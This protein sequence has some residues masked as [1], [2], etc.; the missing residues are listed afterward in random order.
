MIALKLYQWWGIVGVFNRVKAKI[1]RYK[2]SVIAVASLVLFFLLI[3]WTFFQLASSSIEKSRL[4]RSELFDRDLR[5]LIG[6]YDSDERYVLEKNLSQF[7]SEQ[8]PLAPLLLPRQY[9]VALPSGTSKF[10]PR[11]PPRN[12]F[13]DLVKLGSKSIS[14]QK[15]PEKFCAYFAENK[16]VGS[17]L[18]FSMAF[19]DTEINTLRTGDVSFGADSVKISVEN[20]GVRNTWW[21]LLQSPKNLANGERFQLTAFREKTDGVKE[22][23]KRIEGWAYVQKQANNSTVVNLIARLDFK[24][25]YTSQESEIWPPKYWEKTRIQLSRN[26]VSA[27]NNIEQIQ[28]ENTGFS[29]L[30][31]PSLS[32]SIFNAYASL[33]VIA[34]RT[35][36]PVIPS[37]SVK[38]KLKNSAD[39][40]RFVDGDL[41]IRQNPI[42]R[43]Q[44]LQDTSIS[45][46]VRHPGAVIEQSI[47]KTA[48]FIILLLLGFIALAAFFFFQL[49]KPIWILSRHSRQLIKQSS[50][51]ADLPYSD[52]NDEIGALSK[53]FNELLRETR[54]Q[55]A[56]EHEDREKRAEELRKKHIEDVK[57]REI[58]LQVIG[59]E[60]R[61]PLQALKSLHTEQS[62]S[63]R[64]IDRITR[65]VT[66][67][68][69]ASGPEAAFA[70]REINL[71]LLDLGSFLFEVAQNSPLANIPNVVFKGPKSGVNVN[72]D[73]SVLEDALTNILTNGNRHRLQNSPL[74]INL[75]HDTANAIIDVFNDG[76][77][78]PENMLEQIF[79]LYF[80]TENISENQLHGIGLY[81]AKNYISRMDGTI[82][83]HNELLG[84]SF[85]ITLPLNI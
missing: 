18:F 39:F 64:Y 17:Y 9:Y 19:V 23:D 1:G 27:Q 40:I 22:L 25:F 65:A 4:I 63:W 47:W 77:H 34:D 26:D 2:L 35:S 33:N 28:Y 6:H 75:S 70:L 45:F 53:G 3:I 79:E 68:F 58:N 59:H 54:D 62:K 31:I 74:L 56:R 37:G 52:R 55:S 61:S 69:G 13:V 20:G 84:V 42:V 50:S 51:R 43:S 66:Q 14:S 29:N 16:N 57:N 5:E 82:S 11:P 85:R 21:L 32:T 7:L 46:E 30:S 72:V 10:I 48:L 8:R 49:L 15:F 44:L 24:E 38:S 81:A 60:I 12:C 41:L 71:E 83:A 78:I 76:P 36:W 67:L 73:S 80:T